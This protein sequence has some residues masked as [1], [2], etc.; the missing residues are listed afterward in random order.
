LR[1]GRA[2][3][4]G[5]HRPGRRQPRGRAAVR[6]AVGAAV[7]L[8]P[9]AADRPQRRPAPSGADRRD[10][11]RGPA[12][13]RRAADAAASAF[14]GGPAMSTAAA[15]RGAVGRSAVPPWLLTV[16]VTMPTF[17]EVLDTSI[18]NVALRQIAGGLATAPTEG[19]WVITSYLAANAIVLPMS[20][21]L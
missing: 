11:A 16:V 1:E 4:A 21:W 18:A 13:A 9:R 19:E 10:P 5:A 8:R 12:P 20:G 2:A 7:R 6:R 17:M 15:A 3:A 14:A